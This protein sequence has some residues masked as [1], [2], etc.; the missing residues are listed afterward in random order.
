MADTRT[1][2]FVRNLLPR[3]LGG[4][5]TESENILI[6]DHCSHCQ[7]CR[8][9]LQKARMERQSED[10]EAV[11]ELLFLSRL[12]PSELSQK[13]EEDKKRPEARGNSTPSPHKAENNGPEHRTLENKG[14]LVKDKMVLAVLLTTAVLVLVFIGNNIA[15]QNGE[16]AALATA[17][18]V[19][20]PSTVTKEKITEDTEESVLGA[21]VE[22]A[23]EGDGAVTEPEDYA[24]DWKNDTLEALMRKTTGIWTRDIMYSDVCSIEELDFASKRIRD[25]SGL[26]CLR[27]LKVL[28]LSYNYIKDISALSSLTNLTDLNLDCNQIS[29]ISALNSLTN[30]T[31]LDLGLNQISD[32]SALSNLSNLEDLYLGWNNQIS[33]ISALSNLTKLKILHL[34]SNQISDIS[35]LRD[36]DNLKKLGIYDNKISDISAL[37]SLTNLTTLDLNDN[38][39]SNI[40]AL[41]SLTNLTDL[42]LCSNQ[43]SD[44]SAL[45]NL[46]NLT[47]LGLDSNQISDISPL[48]RLF[49]LYTLGISENPIT[50]YSPVEGLNIEHLYK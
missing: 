11:K 35:P 24:I 4:D 37:S 43:I 31:T 47:D 22:T 6:E 3:Y 7:E 14:F 33:D 8:A 15:F 32:I 13:P 36:L 5:C 42:S 44:I 41:S 26:G 9:L 21:D 23:E 19:M 29:D 38:Q 28:N 46:T 34:E 12:M 50:D 27:N 45:S 18:D 1:C 2:I 48:K 17:E 25:I 10:A 40:S 16:E 49:R 39:I 20:E 30:L